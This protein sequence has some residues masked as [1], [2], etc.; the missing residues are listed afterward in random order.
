MQLFSIYKQLAGHAAE[1]MPDYRFRDSKEHCGNYW[2]A[3]ITA[4]LT[5]VYL[6]STRCNASKLGCFADSGI[7]IMLT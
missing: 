5:Q 4:L 3:A 6:R 2:Q 1:Q 7:I